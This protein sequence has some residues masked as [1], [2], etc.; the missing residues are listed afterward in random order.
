MADEAALSEDR[1]SQFADKQ[2]SSA[3][4]TF[5]IH[6]KTPRPAAA[7]AEEPGTA[8]DHSQLEEVTRAA[9]HINPTALVWKCDPSTPLSERGLRALGLPI[10]QLGP[11]C[12]KVTGTMTKSSGR[13]ASFSSQTFHDFFPRPAIVAGLVQDPAA[14]VSVVRACQQSLDASFEWSRGRLW[15]R[16]AGRGAQDEQSVRSFSTSFT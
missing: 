12:L 6:W 11:A 16:G 2:P 14:C 9:R 15:R 7:E 4:P 3:G 13:G 8:V 5:I 10:S 1:A